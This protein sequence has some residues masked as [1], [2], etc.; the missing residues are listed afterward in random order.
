VYGAKSDYSTYDE[1]LDVFSKKQGWKRSADE[2]KNRLRRQHEDLFL[3]GVSNLLQL[4]YYGFHARE[5]STLHSF[6]C[7]TVHPVSCAACMS[8]SGIEFAT[9]IHTSIRM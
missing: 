9:T 1:Q 7:L 5:V 4:L 8:H 2:K 3:Q 6:P